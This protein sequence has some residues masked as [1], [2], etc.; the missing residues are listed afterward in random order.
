MIIAVTGGRDHSLTLT[1]SVWLVERLLHYACVV[2]RHGDCRGVDRDAAKI[3]DALQY[4][5]HGP[6]IVQAWP[7]KEFGDWPACGP[8][9]NEAMLAGYGLPFPMVP[10]S[11]LLA[12]P[13][14]SGT[15]NCKKHAK[16]LHIPVECAPCI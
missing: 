9:R 4:T 2:F 13:G 5:D 8:K 6:V 12:F 3:A 16:R 10:V 15:E 1:Q 11:L 14:E 7:A